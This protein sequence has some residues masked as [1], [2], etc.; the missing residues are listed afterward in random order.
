[1]TKN[2]A[3]GFFALED[4]HYH[5]AGLAA[6]VVIIHAQSSHGTA[7]DGTGVSGNHGQFGFSGYAHH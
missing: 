7:F 5:F 3:A 4:T 1:M 2:A 6:H